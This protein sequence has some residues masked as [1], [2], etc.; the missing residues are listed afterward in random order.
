MSS[1]EFGGQ[2]QGSGLKPSQNYP[3]KP[4]KLPGPESLESPKIIIFVFLG[5]GVP[6]GLPCPRQSR[7][8]FILKEEELG[9]NNRI[10]L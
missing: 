1:G 3:G 9:T 8:G 7:T 5:F 10:F 4:L 2:V 6:L